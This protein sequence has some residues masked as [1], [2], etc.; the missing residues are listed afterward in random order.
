MQ[1]KIKKFIVF[2]SSRRHSYEPFGDICETVQAA[3]GTGGGN[4]P[5]VLEIYEEDDNTVRKEIL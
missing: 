1:E 3:Y 2:D 5:I 4:A